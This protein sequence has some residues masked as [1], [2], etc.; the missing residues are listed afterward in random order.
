MVSPPRRRPTSTSH[1][2]EA[3]DCRGGFPGRPAQGAQQPEPVQV[4]R[5]RPVAPRLRAGPPGED[6]GHHHDTGRGRQ[7]RNRSCPPNS[8]VRRR[9][10]ARTGTPRKCAASSLARFGPG[11][12]HAGRADGAHQHGPR[13]AGR[14]GSKSLRDGLVA[15][16]RRMGGWRGA[17]THLNAGPGGNFE[18]RW[19]C[20]LERGRPSRRHAAR[21]ADGRRRHGD[22]G[23]GAVSIG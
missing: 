22:R 20:C 8:I 19:P 17:V 6:R 1:W 21:L 10:K 2:T 11:H 5:R 13:P 7:G 9:S 4:S 12:H 14:G 23:R 18:T 16:D 3:D 15:Y